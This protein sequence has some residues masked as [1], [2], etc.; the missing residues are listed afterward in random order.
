MRDCFPTYKPRVA[1]AH[2]C[3]S[4]HQPTVFFSSKNKGRIYRDLADSFPSPLF[5][6]CQPKDL[7]HSAIS[8]PEQPT[9]WGFTAFGHPESWDPWGPPSRACLDCSV[10]LQCGCWW[11]PSCSLWPGARSTSGTAGTALSPMPHTWL[12]GK[13][14]AVNQHIGG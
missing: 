12:S 8:Q 11:S 14:M 13:C 7:W 1:T 2:S 3:R 5:H 10:S 6:K 9:R 4:Y